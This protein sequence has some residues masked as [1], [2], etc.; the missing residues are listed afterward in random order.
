MYVLKIIHIHCIKIKSTKIS[1]VKPFSYHVSDCPILPPAGLQNI[2][3]LTYVS[4]SIL[5]YASKKM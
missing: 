3:Q 4:R 2:L 5:E 1:T